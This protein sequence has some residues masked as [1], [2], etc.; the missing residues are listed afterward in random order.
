M[1]ALFYSLNVLLFNFQLIQVP[2]W[3][4]KRKR[5]RGRDIII[6]IV[7]LSLVFR[8]RHGLTSG[9]DEYGWEIS[10]YAHHHHHR[11]TQRK[12]RA[13]IIHTLIRRYVHASK[14][15]RWQDFTLDVKVQSSHQNAS[16]T[17]ARAIMRTCRSSSGTFRDWPTKADVWQIFWTQFIRWKKGTEDTLTLKDHHR[18]PPGRISTLKTACCIGDC[19]LVCSLCFSLFLLFS[20]SLSLSSKN[21][22]NSLVF[23]LSLSYLLIQS[24]IFASLLLRVKTIK[25]YCTKRNLS[26]FGEKSAA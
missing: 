17:E 2:T 6:C 3:T 1:L 19:S 25:W 24:T 13:A 9:N 11:R 23:S 8:R 18:F 16:S 22:H 14:K 5:E 10:R 26:A 7:F 15:L 20:L 21:N 12:Q 4:R